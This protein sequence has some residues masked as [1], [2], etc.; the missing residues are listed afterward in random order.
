MKKNKAQ[1][2]WEVNVKVSNCGIM[3]IEI[4]LKGFEPLIRKLW[5]LCFDQLNYKPLSI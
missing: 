2:I 1:K 4:G 3:I 5:A